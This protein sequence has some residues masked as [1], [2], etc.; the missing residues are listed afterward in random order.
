LTIGD[1]SDDVFLFAG[2]LTATAQ[3]SLTLAGYVRTAGTALVLGN[4]SSS[5]YLA[6]DTV[7]DTTNNGSNPTGGTITLAGSIVNVSGTSA[8]SASD[9]T[10]GAT[11]NLGTWGSV[12]G[13]YGSGGEISKTFTF[14]GSGSTLNFNFYRIDSWDGEYFRIYANN[15]LIVNQQFWTGDYGSVSYKSSPITDILGLLHHGLQRLRVIM[16]FLDGLISDLLLHSQFHLEL[17]L[18]L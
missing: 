6:A 2:G 5:T 8:A 17:L 9:W 14:N 16:L 15:V 4:A 13:I 18:Y 3:S 10:G 11:Y 7:I 12:I 1:Q